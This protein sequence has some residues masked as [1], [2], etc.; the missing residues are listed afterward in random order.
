[1]TI[2][3]VA[4]MY[5]VNIRNKEMKNKNKAKEIVEKILE[6]PKCKNTMKWLDNTNVCI[7]PTCT[8]SISNKKNKND[9]KAIYNVYKILSEKNLKFLDNN[10]LQV[11]IESTEV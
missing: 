4:K 9:S 10:Y 2:N 5:N 8:S 1:M 7:C 3:E 11:A 6:C